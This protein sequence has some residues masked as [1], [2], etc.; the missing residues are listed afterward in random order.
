VYRTLATSV[1]KFKKHA[2]QP[3]AADPDAVAAETR[4]M[5]ACQGICNF[6][7]QVFGARERPT[8]RLAQQLLARGY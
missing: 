2:K 4:L 8:G 7:Q 5:A 1:E 3:V 6:Q